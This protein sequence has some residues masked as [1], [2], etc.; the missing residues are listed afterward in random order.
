MN[1]PPALIFIVLLVIGV[2]IYFYMQPEEEELPTPTPTPTEPTTPTG[3]TAPAEPTAPSGDAVIKLDSL[4]AWYDGPSYD[5]TSRAWKDKSGKGKDITEITGILNKSKNGEEVRGDVDSVV[6][7]PEDILEDEEQ[8]TFISVAK[9]DGPAKGR[10]FTSANGSGENFVLGF[11][12]NKAGVYHVHGAGWLTETVDRHGDKWTLS[13]VQPKLY[14][15]NGTL[16]TGFRPRDDDE[17]GPVPSRIYINGWTTE[18]SDW[19]VKEMIVYRK[20]LTPGEYLA[21]EKVL[22][23]KYDIKP[24][25]YEMSSLKGDASGQGWP[26]IIRDLQ[27]RCGKG[28]ALTK[29]AMNDQ[30]QTMYSCM[31]G[32]DLD[33]EEVEGKSIFED[34]KGTSEYFKNL[35]NKKIDCGESPINA[36]ALAMDEDEEK[37]RYEYTCNNSK[38]KTNTCQT[39]TG[40]AY[41]AGTSVNNLSGL[42]NTAC[43]PDHV[44]TSAKLTQEGAQQK[45]EMTCCKPKGI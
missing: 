17:D 6:A 3:P 37:I 21:I 32:I 8:F 11:H 18:K 29:F 30:K 9:Y 43:P 20:N 42:T 41:D 13:T 45:W 26:E 23:E 2:G 15:S 34:I 19:S 35:Q 38:V 24:N 40:D 28:E 25:R 36:L 22:A 4:V 31:S 12:G 39:I 1:I 27:F 16:R 5:A 44:I 7:F 14:R 33:G 10:I